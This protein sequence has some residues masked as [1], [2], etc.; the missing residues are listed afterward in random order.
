MISSDHDA[1]AA[2]LPEGPLFR[3]FLEAHPGIPSDEALRAFLASHDGPRPV[4]KHGDRFG[5]VSSTLLRDG[6]G[7]PSLLHAPGPPCRT[8]FL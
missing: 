2:D 1:D 8:A 7:G 3:R 5:T 6:P 4:C